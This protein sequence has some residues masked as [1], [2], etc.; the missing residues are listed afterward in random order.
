MSWWNK[1]RLKD[2]EG[3]ICDGA[4]RSGKTMAMTLGFFLWSMTCFEGA[5]FGICG[6]TIGAL[7]RNV[8]TRL[9]QWLGGLYRVQEH[10]SENKLVVTDPAG[11]RNIYYLFGGQDESAA[12]VIQGITLAGVLLDE[13]ALMPRSFLEQACA[14]CSEP[15]SRLWMS[16]NPE[17]QEHWFYKEWILKAPQK[18]LLRLHF[19]MGDNPGLDPKIRSRYETLYTGAFY[20]R[21]VLGQW[22]ASEGLVY[23]FDKALVT[24]QLPQKGRYF[25]SVDY[26]TRNPFSA[27][28]WCVAEG[29]AWRIREYYH[30]GKDRQL[31]DQEYYRQLEILAGALPVEL[32]VIDPSAASMIATIRSYGR[33]RVRKAKNQVLPGIQLV[34]ACLK[35]GLLR[36]S[37]TCTDTIREFGRYRWGEGEKP[38]KQDDHAMDDVRYFC[39]SVLGRMPEFMSALRQCCVWRTDT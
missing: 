15:G 8:I 22:C 13:V 7:R 18:H 1:T 9:P 31:T 38:L 35:A 25:I 34:A 30:R 36:F 5:V 26:G 4:V 17:G 21:F 2:H 23:Q 10:L 28:L 14:R 32:V 24:S 12:Q 11:R 19:T 20:R 27:G 33:F 37:D 6:K 16:C 29:K 3:I 39:M